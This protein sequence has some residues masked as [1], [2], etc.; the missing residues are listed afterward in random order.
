MPSL[1]KAVIVAGA[2][3][4]RDRADAEL[5]GLLDGVELAAPQPV[6]VV[7]VRIALGAA[8]ARAVARRAIVAEG[9]LALARG[10]SEQ[11]GVLLDVIERGLGIAASLA[12]RA[13]LQVLELFS[14]A[15]RA[16]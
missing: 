12:F 16:E 8:A 14:H 7:Q 1:P 13:H 15:P 11:L 9:R 10:R 6:V 2:G 5:D 3:L 4:R